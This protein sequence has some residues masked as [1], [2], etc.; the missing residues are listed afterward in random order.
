MR[1]IPFNHIRIKLIYLF[2]IFYVKSFGQTSDVNKNSDLYKNAPGWA[3]LM[4]ENSPNVNEI[5]NL[6]EKYFETLS[7]LDSLFQPNLI[8]NSTYMAKNLQNVF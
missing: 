8:G 3:K 4:F 1:Q 5:D 6:Y 7:I 2:L